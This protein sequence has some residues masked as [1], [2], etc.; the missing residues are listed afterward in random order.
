MRAHPRL[1][2]TAIV[3]ISAA[4]GGRYTQGGDDGGE[5]ATGSGGGST[6]A[7]TSTGARP[8]GTAG[9]A[10]SAGGTATGTGGKAT[11]TGGKSTGKGGAATCLDIPCPNIDCGPGYIA[12][13]DPSG[14]CKVECRSI[15][16]GTACPGIAC[17]SGSHLEVLPNQCCPTCV[18]DNCEAQRT[19]YNAY[20]QALVDKYSATGCKVDN[21]CA[22]FF[23]KN[24]CAVG[25]GIPMPRDFID[26]LDRN[27]QSYA[28]INCS[29][30]CMLP[31]PPCGPP[32]PPTCFKGY[33]CE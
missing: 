31:M 2:F 4:C 19:K 15:C 22:I 18:P 33:S 23:E 26:S 5:G 3:L 16:E 29:P 32:V 24:N 17:G 28:Q 30:D 10:T 8:T 1:Y 12:V 13:P 20:R 6:G 25:C 21:D 14:C 11:G 27:L 9:K 7:G